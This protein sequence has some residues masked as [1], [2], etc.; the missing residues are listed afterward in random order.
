LHQHAALEAISDSVETFNQPKYHPHTRIQMLEHLLRWSTADENNNYWTA[1]DMENSV[2]WLHGPAGAGKSAIIQTL[3]LRLQDVGRLGGTFFFKRGH[4]SRGNARALFTTLAYQLTLVNPAVRKILSKAVEEDPSLVVRSMPSQLRELIV[5]PCVSVHESDSP[6][7]ILLIDGLDEC[8]GI[9]VQQEI[10]HSIGEIFCGQ[11]HRLKL[12]LASRPEPEIRETFQEIP[13]KSL[14]TLVVERAF[15]DVERFLLREFSRIRKEHNETMAGVDSPW[16][17]PA[18]LNTLVVKSSG[19]FVYAST[20]IKFVDD[21]Q[22][23]PTEQL[24]L[25]LDPTSDAEVHPF[26]PLDQLYFQILSQVPLRLRPRLL[27]ILAVL[28]TNWNL[29]I[30]HIE[31][32][33]GFKAG[34]VRLTLRKLHSVLDLGSH[35]SSPI[36]VSHALFGEFLSSQNRSSIFHVSH[37]YRVDII[38]TALNVLSSTQLLPRGHVAWFV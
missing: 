17:S 29:S 20:V 30:H 9:A 24:E 16:P 5:K 22:F 23:R 33:L 34:D 21:K 25:I 3:A 38:C 26:E 35:D 32:L 12:I 4:P 14:Y 28:T 6:G 11:P 18:T 36:M 15:G 2:L 31:Q 7:R 10:L 19:Y 37:K 8:D 13:S 1:S 27:S